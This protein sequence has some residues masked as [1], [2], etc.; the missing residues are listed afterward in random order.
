MAVLPPFCSALTPLPCMCLQRDGCPKIINLGSAKTDLFY[1]RKKVRL[2]C[3]PLDLPA[4]LPAIA[5]KSCLPA[6]LPAIVPVCIQ[7]LPTRT[8]CSLPCRGCLWPRLP[9]SCLPVRLPIRSWIQ[10][11]LSFEFLSLTLCTRSM[12]IGSGDEGTSLPVEGTRR[13]AVSLRR[14][15]GNQLPAVGPATQHSAGERCCAILV[16]LDDGFA[17]MCGSLGDVEEVIRQ[18]CPMA[19]QDR[20][21]DGPH[22]CEL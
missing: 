9:L 13:P 8:S 12:A 7:G 21:D 11:L 19:M 18:G 2:Y 16:Q 14:P 20:G 5:C 6:C 10:P 4:C 22:L 15:C 17:C 3:L 1:E